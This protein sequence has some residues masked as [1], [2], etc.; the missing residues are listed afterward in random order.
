MTINEALSYT[1]KT[2]S[3]VDSRTLV[4]FI[5]KHNENELINYYDEILD[6]IQEKELESKIKEL[7]SNKPIQ[8]VTNNVN[9]YGLDLYVNENV[10][11]PRFETEELVEN[12]ISLLNNTFVSPKIL[13]LC[14]GS[15]AIGLAIKDKVKDSKVTLSD[16][17]TKALEVANINKERLNLDVEI[18]ESDLFDNID[19]KFD[20]IISNPPY[21][22][23]NEQI[24]E[25]VR[26]NEPSI[27]LYGGKEGLDYY[28]RILKDI[29]KY[30]N[31]KFIIA[32]EI[33]ANQKEKVIE[34]INKYLKNVEII[35]KK[36]LSQ[37]DRMIF[38][39]SI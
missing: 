16:I 26:K 28:E 6:E 3:S 37:K 30:L 2:L 4:A 12:A 22:C 19:S 10:L 9:F 8:Y 21:I 32:F 39:K 25:I 38:I 20:C 11:I 24:E 31:D 5:T 15:G 23:D 1:R 36:D 17:S 34:I 13:D 7:K 18:I 33:G 35:A 27:A 29:S 14:C